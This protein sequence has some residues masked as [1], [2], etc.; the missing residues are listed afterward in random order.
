[1]ESAGSQQRLDQLLATYPGNDPNV[2]QFAHFGAGVRPEVA[3]EL[4]GTVGN[5]AAS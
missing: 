4:P 3:G 2:A 5:R 1:M